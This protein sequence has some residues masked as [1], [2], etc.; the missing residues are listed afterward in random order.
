MPQE[1]NGRAEPCLISGGEAAASELFSDVHPR[2]ND[3]T[4][5]PSFSHL[6]TAFISSLIAMSLVIVLPLNLP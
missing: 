3:G 5:P 2:F 1:V 4:L 6:S